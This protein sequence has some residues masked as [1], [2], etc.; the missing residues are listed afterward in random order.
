MS[1]GSLVGFFC[2]VGTV[3]TK[4][5]GGESSFQLI[6]L[7]GRQGVWGGKWEV[8]SYTHTHIDTI[9]YSTTHT[10]YSK[11]NKLN[12]VYSPKKERELENGSAWNHFLL[13]PRQADSERHGWMDGGGGGAQ[14][15]E[16]WSE[17]GE[18]LSIR[19]LWPPAAVPAVTKSG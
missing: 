2:F 10:L 19:E 4:V 6:G 12:Y 13:S 15:D 17:R 11:Q 9:S 16:R 3:K 7:K 8:R 14:G 1:S 5:L 18:L